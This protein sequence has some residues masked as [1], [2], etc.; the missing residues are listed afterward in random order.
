[1]NCTVYMMNCNC[2]THATC[3]LTFTSYKYNELQVSYAT[4]K[5]GCKASCK[6]PFFFIV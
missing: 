1:M 2:A 3:L 5:L 6:M 4:Q